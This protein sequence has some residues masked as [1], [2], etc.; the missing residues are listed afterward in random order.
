M[1]PSIFRA[2]DIRGVYGKDVTE[3]DV[4]VIGNS[5]A[6]FLKEDKVVVGRDVRISSEGVA[7]A[8]INGF[9]RTGKDVV[10]VGMVSLGVGSLYAWKRRLPFAYITASHMPAEWTGIKFFCSNGTGFMEEDNYKIRDLS[11]EGRIV[12]KGT[13]RVEN[14]DTGKVIEEYVEFLLSKI[15]PR[16]KMK[17]LLDCGNGAACVVARKLFERAG[18]DVDVLFE[19]PDGSFPNRSPDNFEDPLTVAKERVREF[20]FGIAYDGDGDRAVI[21]DCNGSVLTPEQTSYIILEELIQKEEGPVIAN[22]ECTK[23]IDIIPEKFGREVKRIRVGHT[24]LMDAVYREKACFGAE[25][26][27]HYVIPSIF[28]T[29]D[30]LAVSYYFACVLSSRDSDLSEIAKGIP[31]YPFKRVNFECDDERKFMVMDRIK[32][33]MMKEHE[34]V[35]TLDG[36]RIDLEK[37]WVL[38][39][40][41]NTSPTIR[42]TMEGKDEQSFEEIK[43]RFSAIIEEEISASEPNKQAEQ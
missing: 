10:D 41:S 15:R 19:E 40:P 8:F 14:E 31:S 34:N 13:G 36:V 7:R 32:E 16:K 42:L 38:V 5:M 24:F 33:R 12:D 18:F 29:D 9:S 2:Y 26:A 43:N 35:N 30:S 6:R 3:D 28:P 20:D 1:H 39:R 37:G 4:G 21:I 25:R 23:V 27:G 17:I 22:V 11:L